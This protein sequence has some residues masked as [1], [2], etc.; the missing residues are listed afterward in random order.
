MAVY[1][2][3]P[4]VG[5][6]PAAL[7]ACP[8]EWSQLAAREEEF[9]QAENER[10]LYVAATRAGTCLIVSRREKKVATNP[11]Q[12]LCEALSDQGTHQDPGPQPPPVR[13][14]V[15]V[16]AA[17]VDAAKTAI[18]ER[19]AVVRGATYETERMKE[20][21]LRRSRM[22]GDRDASAPP[23]ARSDED[24][25][26][27]DPT[28]AGE[29]GVEW[30]E[31][32]HAL[33][34][35]AMRKPDADI[36]SLARSLTRDRELGDERVTALLAT[37][38]AVRQ[39]AIWNRAHASERV[40]AEVPL[41][42]VSPPAESVAGRSTVRRGVIDLAFREPE[43][44]VIVDYKTDTFDRRSISELVEHYRPQVESYAEAWRT[45]VGEP[46]HEVGLFFTSANRYERLSGKGSSQ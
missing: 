30:G 36:E 12:P 40:L 8:L 37:V 15:T 1:E 28:A 13:P 25:A 26:V 7:L 29:H 4:E 44:W 33:L 43:G 32:V 17:D 45:I 16:T 3:R 5:Y 21:S 27:A 19:F 42:M 46:V 38:R 35:A 20:V 14:R 39:S 11:W 23:F 10:L 41:M 24:G 22:P 2:P 6:K 9:Q 34:E 31:D 18:D